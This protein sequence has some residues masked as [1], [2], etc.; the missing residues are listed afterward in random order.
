MEAMINFV[1]TSRDKL[2]VEPICKVL[3]I[4]E[5]TCHVHTARRAN[6]ETAPS[7]IKREARFGI[8]TRRAFDEN[9][10]VYGVRKIWWQLLRGRHDVARC[11][12]RA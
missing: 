6:P 1:D 9:F 2:G 7:R 12:A 11:T 8:A 4:A 5:S 10:Q 3:P